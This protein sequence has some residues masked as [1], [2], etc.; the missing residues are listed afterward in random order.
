MELLAALHCALA[1]MHQNDVDESIDNT[2]PPVVD[3]E[4]EASVD[5]RGRVVLAFEEEHKCVV[6]F[7]L[8]SA[9]IADCFVHY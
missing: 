6:V 1:H 7:V 4:V 9:R 5:V 2:Q 3:N 8:E